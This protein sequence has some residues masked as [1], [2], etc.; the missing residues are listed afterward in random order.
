MKKL[1]L[2]HRP[3][4]L[5]MAFVQ[6]EGSVLGFYMASLMPNWIAAFFVGQVAVLAAV[7]CWIFL[8]RMPGSE[9]RREAAEKAAQVQKLRE[10]QGEPH[11]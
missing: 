1:Y 3:S 6:F 2:T 10:T 9:E 11:V 4:E 5:G 7:M 8:F